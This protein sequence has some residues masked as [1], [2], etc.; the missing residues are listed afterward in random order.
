MED[1]AFSVVYV[2][3]RKDPKIAWFVDSFMRELDG[4][5][6]GIEVLVVAYF[7]DAVREAVKKAGAESWITVH[8][9]KP[10][11]WQGE[12]KLT[13]KDWFAAANARNT[14][15]ALSRGHTIVFVD[16]LSAVVPG[17]WEWAKHACRNQCVCLGT[18]EKVRDLA[19]DS[20]GALTYDEAPNSCGKDTR[21]P[22]LPQPAEDTKAYPAVGGW[23]YGSSVAC[24][25]EFLLVINGFDEEC[26]GI[27][28][29][30][31]IAGLML[32][33]MEFPLFI[34]PGMKTVEDDKMHYVEKP[35]PR[36][37]RGEGETDSAW[38]ILKKVQGA[39]RVVA[40]NVDNLRDLRDKVLAGEPFPI[41]TKPDKFWYDETPLKELP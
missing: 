20:S 10:N 29:E 35:F 32:D 38:T 37:N 11:V 17:W 40:P 36:L 21:L 28:T 16:D 14:G 33:H 4:D 39:E 7:E 22:M 41:P 8:P 15:I 6:A 27:G 3:N 5:L 9:P 2:T 34:C 19:V 31:Y 30:D 25:I 24:P 13:K 12:H 1:V 26:N 18:Y 23:L